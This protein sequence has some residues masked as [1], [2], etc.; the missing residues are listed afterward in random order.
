MTVSLNETSSRRAVYWDLPTVRSGV[1]NQNL[2]VQSNYNPGDIFGISRNTIQYIY[3]DDFGHREQ[4]S[5]GLSVEGNLRTN[6]S[7]SVG[8]ESLIF[9]FGTFGHSDRMN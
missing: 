1:G 5:F 7:P 4:C 2:K 3:E 6:I 9:P 8:Y